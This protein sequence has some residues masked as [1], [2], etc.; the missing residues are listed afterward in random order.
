MATAT[1]AWH[2]SSVGVTGWVG[3]AVAAAVLLAATGAGLWL[4]AREGRV[5]PAGGAPPAA[6][7]LGSL[8]VEPGTP[9][10][11]LQ[12]SSAFCARCRATRIICR[13]LAA[14]R[15][16]VRHVEVDAES[17]LDA[18]RALGVWRTPTVFVVDSG[19]HPVSRV[20]GQPTRDQLVEAITPLVGRVGSG[21]GSA[22]VRHDSS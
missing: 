6:D 14:E 10:T 7:L 20:T 8:G 12:F 5:R 3:L 9:V 19:G 18:V 22:G 16:G 1:A 15:D 2:G 4:R 11:L 21:S 17:H 13:R